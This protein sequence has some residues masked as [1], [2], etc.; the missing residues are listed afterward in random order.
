VQ[1]SQFSRLKPL[2]VPKIWGSETLTNL[3]EK[4]SIR[5]GSELIGET[6]EVS[7]L[8]EGQSE[9][10][11]KS[12]FLALGFRLPY[13]V[14]FLGTSQ[15]LSIQVHPN[16]LI[17]KKLEGPLAQGKDECWIVLD[18]LPDAKI[19]IGVKPGVKKAQ[20]QAAIDHGEDVSLL[21][22]SYPAQKGQ[23]Y[24]VPAGTIHALGAGLLLAE[25]QSSSGITYRLWDWNR[26]DDSGKLRTLHIEQGL[27]SLELSAKKNSRDYFQY[28]NNIL[29]LAQSPS[30]SVQ[31]SQFKMELLTGDFL[32]S[33]KPGFAVVSL[34]SETQVEAESL[35]PFESIIITHAGQLKG[36]GN[37]L[38]ISY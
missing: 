27:A 4:Y 24:F 17:A 32:I 3:K 2:L 25:V 8:N 28:Q 30:F 22:Q 9:V 6:W 12:L 10:A 23:F 1:K 26:L 21:L 36:R 38:L 15:H 34:I 13:M 18:A 33:V 20:L 19:F 14:K 7:T 35:E 29:N 31:F 16:D 5:K 37:C 11:G